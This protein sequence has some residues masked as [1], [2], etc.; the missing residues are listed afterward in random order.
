MGLRFVARSVQVVAFAMKFDELRAVEY[1]FGWQ[2]DAQRIDESTVHENFIMKLGIGA[3]FRGADVSQ[4]LALT[5]LRPPD[6]TGR[7]GRQMGVVGRKRS[8][9]TAQRQVA[10]VGGDSGMAGAQ[11]LLVDRERPAHQWFGL[12]ETVAGLQQLRQVV[13]VS[14]DIGMVGAQAM[15]NNQSRDRIPGKGAVHTPVHSIDLSMLSPA[16]SVAKAGE[17]IAIRVPVS[18]M[19]GTGDAIWY[20]DGKGHAACDNLIARRRQSVLISGIVGASIF[21]RSG[22]DEH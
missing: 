12:G 5:D 21:C 20:S 7:D 8:R 11:L 16:A 19:L 10:E 18:H 2:S 6:D 3:D 1:T 15:I 17:T 13:E 4:H 22:H 14:G 9:V